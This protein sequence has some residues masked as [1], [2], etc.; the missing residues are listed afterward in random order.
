MPRPL[1]A[2]AKAQ[3]MLWSASKNETGRPSATAVPNFFLQNRKEAL[4]TE[5]SYFLTLRF[6]LMQFVQV[7]K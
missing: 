7:D 1:A 2:H 6:P 5:S 3:L 4:D